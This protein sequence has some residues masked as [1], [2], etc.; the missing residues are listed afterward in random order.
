MGRTARRNP[1]KRRGR[2]H[3]PA[4]GPMAGPAVGMHGGLDDVPATRRPP[5]PGRARS[6]PPGITL[7]GP[8]NRWTRSP[9]RKRWVR[10]PTPIPRWMADR[11]EG[12]DLPPVER[13]TKDPIAGIVPKCCRADHQCPGRR[14]RPASGAVSGLGLSRDD[15]G[16]GAPDRLGSLLRRRPRQRPPSC[17]LSCLGIH[18]LVVVRPPSALGRYQACVSPSSSY[19]WTASRPSGKVVTIASSGGTVDLDDAISSCVGRPSRRP[20]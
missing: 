1:P 2:H 6:V 17:R 9:A 19:P 18:G 14:G 5:C 10:L 4:S 7:G 13:F 11:D 20:E 16:P 3:R 15:D 12:R 8:W